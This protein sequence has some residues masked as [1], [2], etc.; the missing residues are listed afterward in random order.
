MTKPAT[1]FA[2]ESK[3]KSKFMDSAGKL[4]PENNVPDIFGGSV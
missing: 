2:R 4:I 1:S 3:Y